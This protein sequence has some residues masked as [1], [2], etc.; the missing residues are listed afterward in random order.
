MYPDDDRNPS[1][2]GLV[3]TVSL[4][5]PMLNWIYAERDT[6]ELLYGNRT[7][8]IEHIVGPWD[9]S[10]PLSANDGPEH[11]NPDPEGEED[12]RS[13]TL[14]GNDVFHI[15]ENQG[16][17]AGLRWSLSSQLHSSTQKGHRR[18]KLVRRPLP[19]EL[20]KMQEMEAENKMRVK[21]SGDLK[22]T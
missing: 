1:E 13:L 5:P 20:R 21:Q 3:S 16:R 18:C 14:A 4:D 6:G 10:E 12:L 2:R 19:G 8:S 11:R 17:E 22:T 15:S 7:Q 9:W